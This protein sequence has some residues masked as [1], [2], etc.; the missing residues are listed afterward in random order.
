[1]DR[2]VTE[3]LGRVFESK[4]GP[5]IALK[6]VNLRVRA[7]EVFGLLGPNGAGK[8]TLIRILT[9]LLLPTSG[10][11]Y[12]EGYDVVKEA[13][14]VREIVGFVSS[15]EKVGF[16]FATARLNLWFFSQLYGVPR[17]VAMERIEA[18]AEAL[19]FK[20][21]LDRRLYTFTT[22]YRQRLNIARAFI[23]D[24]HVVFL[25]EPTNGM[26]VMSAKT[27]RELLVHE[28]KTKLRT[29]FIATH[30]MFEAEE[31]CDRVA[32]ID[33]GE[34]L[35]LDAP[36]RL[37]SRLSD[38]VVLLETSTARIDLEEVLSVRGV[39]GGTLKVDGESGRA[40]I[41]LVLNDETGLSHVIRLL[42]SRNVKIFLHEFIEP[43]LEDVF[44]SL[45][46]RGFAERE[47]EDEK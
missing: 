39:R 2:V 6:S 36:E 32:I 42:E 24:P 28:A 37:K 34:I 26:D 25:D 5:V 20:D 40:R 30:N 18:L 8:T 19:H 3:N 27:V 46:G 44:V 12:V 22:G 31:I 1:M 23:H 9:T 15:S 14:K 45:V 38:R 17:R 7:G 13:K 47:S 29:I 43:T 11:A 33:N 41:R 21:Q 10:S 16:D 4:S 35:A